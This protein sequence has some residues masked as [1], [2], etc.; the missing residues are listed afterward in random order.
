[1]SDI[2]LEEQVQQV[3]EKLQKYRQEA[4]M[5]IKLAEQQ[6]QEARALSSHHFF[7]QL[8]YFQNS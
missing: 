3:R 7:R 8:F 1:M 4:L 2:S 5:M 6:R